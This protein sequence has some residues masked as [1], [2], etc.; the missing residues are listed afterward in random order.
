[1]KKL[2][3]IQNLTKFFPVLGG[4]F[5]RPVGWVKAVDDVS[6]H[7]Y[8]GETFSLVGETGSGKT[9]TGKT[10]LRLIEPTKGKIIFDGKDVTSIP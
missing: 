4:V 7:V 9:T 6:F 5:S 8:E 1:M 3:D 10:I 2:I